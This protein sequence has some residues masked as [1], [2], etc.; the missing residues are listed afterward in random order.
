MRIRAF[1]GAAVLGMAMMAFAPVAMA[2]SDVPPDKI[3]VLDL[4]H[5]SDVAV[6]VIAALGIPDGE[7]CPA[8][9]ADVRLDPASLGGDQGEAAPALC[10]MVSF[11]PVSLA[12]RHED[13][14]RCSV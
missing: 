9:V 2:M 3:C 7:D 1:I 10:S 12:Y 14:G 5:P 4:S 8:A 6:D 13:P 11:L